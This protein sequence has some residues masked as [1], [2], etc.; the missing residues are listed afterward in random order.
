MLAAAALA[1]QDSQPNALL[2][3]WLPTETAASELY[4]GSAKCIACHAEQASALTT[5][6]GDALHGWSQ[7]DFLP[8]RTH[9][10]ALGP[11]RYR[12][13]DGV[14]EVTEEELDRIEEAIAE[15]RRRQS[16]E[17]EGGP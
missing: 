14:Y 4:A 5:A 7:S 11:Y 15:A 12:I 17:T 10:L 1:A 2:P 8:G 16:E 9:T 6:M 13:A 3:D